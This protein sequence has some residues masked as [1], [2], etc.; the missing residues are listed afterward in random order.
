MIHMKKGRV[1]WFTR[2]IV[3]RQTMD[4]QVVVGSRVRVCGIESRPALNGCRGRVISLDVQRSRCGVLLDDEEKPYSLRR[5]CLVSL[6]QDSAEETAQKQELPPNQLQRG[7]TGM[8]QHS[9]EQT[10]HVPPSPPQQQEIGLPGDWLHPSDRMEDD[11]APEDIGCFESGWHG[12]PSQPL[13]IAVRDG[14]CDHT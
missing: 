1:L 10:A 5:S 8:E 7:S 13:F 9:A 6:Q 2:L 3:V 11:M 4:D 14:Q 12:L